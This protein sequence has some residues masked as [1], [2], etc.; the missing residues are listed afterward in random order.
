MANSN[1]K[2]RPTSRAGRRFQPM[3]N[4]TPSK[5][6]T[7][8]PPCRRMM[9]YDQASLLAD[10]R[11]YSSRAKMGGNPLPDSRRRLSHP[12]VAATQNSNGRFLRP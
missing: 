9:K 3:V 4:S 2:R 6:P 11:I 12:S 5:S 10:L 8:K 1:K 7:G